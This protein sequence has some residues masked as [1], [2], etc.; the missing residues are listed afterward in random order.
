MNAGRI[1]RSALAICALIGAGLG[2]FGTHPIHNLPAADRARWQR[3]IHPVINAQCGTSAGSQDPVY[4]GIC[5]RDL[6]DRYAAAQ[7]RKAWLKAHG[8]IPSM[9][10]AY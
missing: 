4:R 1:F 3:C 7:N 9:V 2:C 5:G 10:D 6:A 8:C